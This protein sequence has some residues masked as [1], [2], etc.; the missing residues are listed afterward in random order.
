M[1]INKLILYLDTNSIKLTN[2]YNALDKE[3]N[4]KNTNKNKNTIKIQ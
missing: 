2:H 4:Y 1:Y 3:N